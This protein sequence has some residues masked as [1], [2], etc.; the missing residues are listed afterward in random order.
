MGKYNPENSIDTAYKAI[1]D[2]R[3]SGYKF[4]GTTPVYDITKDDLRALMKISNKYGIP[5]EWMINLIRHESANTFNPAVTNYIGATGLIQFLKSTAIN[6]GT[7]TDDLRK[8]TFQQQ[9]VYV[10]K[11]LQRNLKRY[12]GPD[13]KVPSTFTQGD[14]FMTIFYP[15]AV[16]KPNYVFPGE[17]SRYN[18]GV[19]T[20][21][22]YVDKSLSRAIF[23]T[24]IFPYTLKDFKDKF[25]EFWTN[26]PKKVKIGGAILAL[27]LLGTASWVIYRTIKNKP[28]IPKFK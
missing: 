15:V 7:T 20:P 26:T 11:Y 21:K 3:A 17:V 13:G 18:P 4:G 19:Y 25:G 24:S 5:F 16:L 1:Q 8:M 22:D 9:L 10:D 6:L 14:L 23:P 28:I 12:L 27:L 2:K